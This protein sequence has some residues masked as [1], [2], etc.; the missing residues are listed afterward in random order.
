MKNVP[1]NPFENQEPKVIL[2]T[3]KQTDTNAFYQK[4]HA[5]YML[6]VSFVR[7]IFISKD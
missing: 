5:A 7:N 2:A 3:L 4:A 1:R 6:L